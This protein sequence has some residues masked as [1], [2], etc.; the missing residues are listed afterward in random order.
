MKK[1]ALALG[2]L[3]RRRHG[4]S[5]RA[6]A[7]KLAV[8]ASTYH[9]WQRD[10]SAGALERRSR[11]RPP[12]RE[13]RIVRAAVIEL[14]A[15]TDGAISVATLKCGFPD[16]SRSRLTRMLKA[17][18]RARASHRVRLQWLRPGTVWA[19][20]YTELAPT[21]DGQRRWALAV[22]DLASGMV[23][24][25]TLAAGATAER[26]LRGPGAVVRRARP[27]PGAQDG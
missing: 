16:V 15:A 27:A 4:T 2:R 3:A 11:G 19:A 20:D 24:A 13:P 26:S 9:G 8:P 17:Y 10:W 23:L 7:R 1:R 18:R 22:R 25:A 21:P 12:M 14:I 6:V 5:A